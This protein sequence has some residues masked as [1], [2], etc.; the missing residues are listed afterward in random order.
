MGPRFTLSS[1]EGRRRSGTERAIQVRVNSL[2]KLVV[3]IVAR[4][5]LWIKNTLPKNGPLYLVLVPEMAEKETFALFTGVG[6]AGQKHQ[7]GTK[8][9]KCRLLLTVPS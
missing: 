8:S 1:G 3:E 2:W 7:G 5:R 9:F 6:S 4:C